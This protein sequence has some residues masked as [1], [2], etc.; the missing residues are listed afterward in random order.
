MNRSRE[1]IKSPINEKFTIM[2]KLPYWIVAVVIL[3]SLNACGNSDTENSNQILEVKKDELREKKQELRELKQTISELEITIEEMENGQN[4]VEPALVELDTIK[5]QDLKHFTVF[6][7][8]VGTR[9]QVTATAEVSGRILKL[10]VE[11][12]DQVNQGDLIARLD[13]ELIDRQMAEVETTLSLARD[14]FQRQKRL[15]DQNIG[16]EVQFLEAQNSVERLKR[17]M[18]VLETQKSKSVVRA[19][20]SGTLEE[21]LLRTGEFVSP[22]TPIGLIVDTRNLKLSVNIPEN[23]LPFVNRG[24]RVTID[25]PSLGSTIEASISRIGSSIDPENRTFTVEANL[26]TGL[27]KVKPNLMASISLNDRTAENAIVIPLNIVQN[28]I[29]GKSF[30][31][32][33]EEIN[34]KMEAKKRYITTGLSYRG[35]IEVTSGLM[36]D[37]L[38]I[39]RG[40]QDVTDQQLLVTN[41]R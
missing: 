40:H 22:G 6:Q 26:P 32:V 2:K 35:R 14:V 7:G 30:V 20:K 21:L 34:G 38:L 8:N 12:G 28:E 39:V 27:A 15:W 10:M 31:Y 18:E 4:S 13:T 29:G 17:N 36:E 19:P 3:S 37:E 25:F 24:D 1:E 23:Y 9:N 11:E 33:A 16:S 5:K 41:N